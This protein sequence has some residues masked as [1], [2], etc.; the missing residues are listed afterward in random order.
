MNRAA[1]RKQHN[2]KLTEFARAAQKQ[3][4]GVMQL[5]F[6]W[7]EDA[8]QMAIQGMAGDHASGFALILA[9]TGLR[10]LEERPGTLCLL[11]DRKPTSSDVSVVAGLHAL[12]D[13]PDHAICFL[14]CHACANRP[15]HELMAA[16]RDKVLN[17]FTGLRSIE[18]HE[19]EGHA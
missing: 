11:C 15:R 4:Q 14:I 3:G 16:T 10:I 19:A 5:T 18:I 9:A 2:A 17:G 8:I 6:V 7:R 13:S 1:R 12:H